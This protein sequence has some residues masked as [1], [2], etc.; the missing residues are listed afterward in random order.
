[1][2]VREIY[3]KYL[4]TPNLQKHH[5]RV[6]KVALFIYDH[7][8]GEQFDKELVK[9]AALLHDLGNIVKFDLKGYPEYL[10][11]ELKRRDF[12]A[13]KQKEMIKKYGDDDHKACLQ[14]LREIGVDA[15][16]IKIISDKSF[17]NSL[18]TKKSDNWELKI[19]FYSDLR[20]GPLGV[21]S[22]KER[23]DEAIPRLKMNKK[24]NNAGE[25]IKACYRIEKQI[26][27]NL[28]VDVSKITDQSIE[29]DDKELLNT[30]I[31]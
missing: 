21:I 12:W 29:R 31:K 30:I 17:R 15:K 11:E 9:K 19:L 18:K 26:Q 7:W 4:I 1:M 27:E 13:K 22:V 20:V 3:K 24:R 10:G 5:L 8:K 23:F 2:K 6:A 25:L 14:M 28:D 16:I